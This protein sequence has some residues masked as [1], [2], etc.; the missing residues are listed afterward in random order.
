MN[1]KPR[2]FTYGGRT[3]EVRA[4]AENEG[5][6][7]RVFE[8]NRPVTAVVYTVSHENQIDAKIQDLPVDLLQELMRLAQSDVEQGRVALL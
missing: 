8:N 5:W 3:F 6:K 1:I 2:T 4:A 7:V